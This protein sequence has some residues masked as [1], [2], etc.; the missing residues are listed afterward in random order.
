MKTRDERKWVS[1]Y[2]G[3]TT[4]E[5]KRDT[6]DSIHVSSSKSVLHVAIFNSLSQVVIRDDE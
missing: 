3:V 5:V 2:D 4:Y 1:P 6:S